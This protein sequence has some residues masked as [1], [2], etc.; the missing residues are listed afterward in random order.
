[1]KK[2]LFLSIIFLMALT[3]TFSQEKTSKNKA[4]HMTE[5]KEKADYC[6][7]KGGKMYHYHN[8]KEELITKEK[9]WETMKVMP[10]GTCMMKDGKSV[11]LKEGQCCDEMG[12]VHDDCIKYPIK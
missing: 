4:S 2:L 12:K 3:T 6:I 7:M 10:D 11:K 5:K 8:G 9:K 1:M